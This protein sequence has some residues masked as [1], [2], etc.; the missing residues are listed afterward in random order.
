MKR[1]VVLGGGESGVGAALL[2]KEKGFEVFLSDAGN[3][4]QNK[5]DVLSHADIPF[6][7][8]GHTEDRVLI[9]D[10]VVKSPGIPD[11]AP[12]IR[13]LDTLRIPVIDELEFAARFTKGKLL[14]VTGTNGKTTTVKLFYHILQKANLDVGLAGNVG[15]SLAR[16]LLKGD[17]DYWVLEVS[18]FQLDRIYET[19]FHVAILLNITPDHLDRYNYEFARYVD[20]KFRITRSQ[21]EEDHFIYSVDSKAVVDELQN[22]DLKAKQYSFSAMG[23]Q[24]G[25][26][27]WLENENLIINING[28]LEMS[29]QELAL[30]GKHNASNGMASG[31]ASRIL[32]IRKEIIRDSLSD[33]Q[34]VEHRLEHVTTVSGVEYINDSKATNINSTWYAL[35]SMQSQTVWIVGGVDKGNDYSELLDLVKDRVKAIIALGKDNSRIHAAFDN[36]VPVIHDV[37]EMR[38]AVGLAYRESRK[39]E[40]VLLSPA[41]ASF[42]LFESY[43]DRGNQFKEYVRAL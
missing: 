16:Q 34:N 3:L 10:E 42:D 40:A 8:G 26:N 32:E 19:R 18:S 24:E 17:R 41:C 1:I 5:K 12:L 7:E 38:D 31:I 36:V 4:K 21:T 39:G 33:F 29:I 27:A 23:Y 6:E 43:E 22:R 37:T 11:T 14:A 28:E 13:K 15:Q 2:A 25:L 20:S 35:E 9:A 30:Q